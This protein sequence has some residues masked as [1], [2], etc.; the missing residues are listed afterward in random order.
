MDHNGFILAIKY[1][2]IYGKKRLVRDIITAPVYVP[3]RNKFRYIPSLL[4]LLLHG[5]KFLMLQLFV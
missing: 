1:R 5:L 4:Q 2:C 3:N